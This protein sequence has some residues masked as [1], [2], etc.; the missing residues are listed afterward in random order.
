ME[1][2]YDLLIVGAIGIHDEELAVA[3]VLRNAI[4]AN[5]IENFVLVGR[6]LY[7]AKAAK[8]HEDFRRHASVGD[9]HLMA[10][11]VVRVARFVDASII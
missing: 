10:T 7:V 11:D 1:Q 8:C 5:S 9:S 2:K 3:L 6:N 4:V